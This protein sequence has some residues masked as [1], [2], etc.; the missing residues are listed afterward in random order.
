[1]LFPVIFNL[2]SK[3]SKTYHKDFLLLTIA[4][5]FNNLCSGLLPDPNF[6]FNIL[7]QNILAYTVG[8][9]SIIYFYYYLIRYYDIHFLKYFSVNFV[10]IILSIDLVL[11]FIIPYTITEDLRIS[12]LTF[13]IIPLILVVITIISAIRNKK[14]SNK[15]DYSYIEKYHTFTG[16][17]GLFSICSV[18]IVLLLFGDQQEIEQTLFNLGYFFIAIEYFLCNKSL[19][20]YSIKNQFELTEREAELLH[21]LILNPKI[22]YLEL[23]YKLN[24]TDK[25]VSAHMSRIFKKLDVGNRKELREFISNYKNKI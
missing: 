22:K 14:S 20:E 6:G 25:T 18:P 19:N 16:I 3:S 2:I 17:M 1:M 8:L 7:S 15:K 5:L 13:L 23:G 12:N 24:I 21:E 4:I 11:G 9:V 10:L